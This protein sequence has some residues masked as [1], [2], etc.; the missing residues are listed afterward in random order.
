MVTMALGESNIDHRGQTMRRESSQN[1]R[2]TCQKWVES[3]YKIM[4]CYFH[5]SAV[6]LHHCS[7][8]RLLEP[9]PTEQLGLSVTY[10]RK[11]CALGAKPGLFSAAKT[12]HGRKPEKRDQPGPSL[13]ALPKRWKRFFSFK[14]IRENI[15][16]TTGFKTVFKPPKTH[17]SNPG[18]SSAHHPPPRK[19]CDAF[20]P[21]PGTPWLIN[22]LVFWI[23]HDIYIANPTGFGNIMEVG[24]LFSE[25]NYWIFDANIL[26]LSKSTTQE[27]SGPPK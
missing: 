26:T 2:Y 23:Q 25:A 21:G 3:E 20:G 11:E 5:D 18:L 19:T 1:R 7:Q 10:C 22:G 6:A 14:T 24:T 12:H 16:T 4:K 13:P 9:P 8:K 17:L 27:G 15:Q